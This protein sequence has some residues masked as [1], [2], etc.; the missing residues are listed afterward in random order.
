MVKKRGCS[1]AWRDRL[2]LQ[3]PLPGGKRDCLSFETI[4][5]CIECSGELL[6]WAQSRISRRMLTAHTFSPSGSQAVQRVGNVPKYRLMWPLYSPLAIA[7]WPV[8]P[9]DCGPPNLL[10]I[11][12]MA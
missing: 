4:K 2:G 6:R 10:P 9:M 3:P 11:A 12:G 1:S 7:V 5:H 8:G